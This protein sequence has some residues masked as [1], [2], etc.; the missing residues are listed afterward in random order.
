MIGE[1]ES[2]KLSDKTTVEVGV[3][4]G[5]ELGLADL[6]TAKLIG[7]DMLTKEGGGTVPIMEMI[8]INMR[9]YAVCSIRKI[10]GEAM[11]P[12]ANRATWARTAAKLGPK[13]YNVL[14]AWASNVYNP[15][16][17]E[18]KKALTDPSLE[19]LPPS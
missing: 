9:A 6:I 17:G 1:P 13:E 19:A 16:E 11:N 15:D 18:L 5:Y 2:L 7:S 14:Q 4:D 3:L 10:N 8:L 12:L